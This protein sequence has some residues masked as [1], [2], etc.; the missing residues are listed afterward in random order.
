MFPTVCTDEI[1][2]LKKRS[3]T[4]ISEEDRN[5][6]FSGSVWLFSASE[7]EWSC[8]HPNTQFEQSVHGEFVSHSHPSLPFATSLCCISYPICYYFMVLLS[9]LVSFLSNGTPAPEQCPSSHHA[10]Q[11]LPSVFPPFPSVFTPQHISFIQKSSQLFITLFKPHKK[12][13]YSSAEGFH[14]LLFLRYHICSSEL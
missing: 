9:D 8:S 10:R 3:T 7:C 14:S 4:V 1:L 2:N 11:S 13:S 5:L 12:S 6:L